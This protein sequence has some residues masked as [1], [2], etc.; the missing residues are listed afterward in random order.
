VPKNGVPGQ[1][2]SRNPLGD[3]MSG[4]GGMGG[5]VSEE[6]QNLTKKLNDL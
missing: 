3:F 2:P 5:G 6:V 1:K 4:F